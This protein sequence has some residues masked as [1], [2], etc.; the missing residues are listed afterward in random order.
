MPELHWWVTDD[1]KSSAFLD[2]IFAKKKERVGGEGVCSALL[3][4]FPVKVKIYFLAPIYS[5]SIFLVVQDHVQVNKNPTSC[6]VRMN[7]INVHV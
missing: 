6:C 1:V 5:R 4:S 3:P 7:G 2:W